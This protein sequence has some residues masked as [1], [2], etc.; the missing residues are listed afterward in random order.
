MVAAKLLLLIAPLALAHGQDVAFV[1]IQVEKFST[2]GSEENPVGALTDAM[3][4]AGASIV[5]GVQHA[6]GHG[7][8]EDI[9]AKTEA[10]A[11]NKHVGTSKANASKKHVGGAKAHAKQKAKQRHIAASKAKASPK[12]VGASKANASQKHVVASKANASKE[13]V[14]APKAT[15]SRKD[16]VAPKANA[17]QEHVVAPKATESRKDDVAPQ[18]NASQKHVSASK[19]NASQEHVVAPKATES[20]KDDVASKANAS[21]KHVVAPKA[22]TSQEHR[23]P[24][25]MHAQQHAANLAARADRRARRKVRHAR[26]VKHAANLA[27]RKAA[28]RGGTS[29]NQTQKTMQVVSFHLNDANTEFGDRIV[30]VG[31]DE[32]FGNWEPTNG[33]DLHTDNHTFPEWKLENVSVVYP[34]NVVE[35]KFVVLKTTGDVEWEQFGVEANRKLSMSMDAIQVVDAVFGVLA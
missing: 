18:A 23:R 32:Q 29:N 31:D 5:S 15:E 13:H 16:D 30:I 25:A 11:S 8:D 1:Q 21:Q 12:R 24:K 10:N 20:P 28:R 33:M 14:V 2:N 7:T 35:Y 4:A 26:R 6:L 22:N 19:A 9:V 34:S 17:S 3:K 27:A